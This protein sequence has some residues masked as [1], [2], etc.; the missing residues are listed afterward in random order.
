MG[1]L[2]SRF[3]VS[4]RFGGFAAFGVLKTGNGGWKRC[5][6]GDYGPAVPIR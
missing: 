2:R 5:R 3:T 4:H 1:D 6:I